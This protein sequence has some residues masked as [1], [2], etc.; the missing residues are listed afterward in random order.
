M[1]TREPALRSHSE[2]SAPGCSCRGRVRIERSASPS[3]DPA[4]QTLLACLGPA[5]L[6]PTSPS[7]QYALQACI[8]PEQRR[9]DRHPSRPL[10]L[11]G[12]APH[13]PLTV[14][15]TRYRMPEERS[16]ATFAKQAATITPKPAI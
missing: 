15:L 2:C 4:V 11:W 9:S 7:G 6:K 12:A 13:Q 14:P 5:Q 16:L 1:R 8:V 10:A 3:D